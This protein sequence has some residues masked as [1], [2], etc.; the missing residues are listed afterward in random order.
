MSQLIMKTEELFI[1]ILMK[2]DYSH[3]DSISV[4]LNVDINKSHIR[5]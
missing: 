2:R 1:F 4:F 3:H 5:S